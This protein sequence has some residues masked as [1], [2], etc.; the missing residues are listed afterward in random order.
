MGVNLVPIK[1]QILVN[2]NV[3]EPGYWCNSS[4]KFGREHP[5]FAHANNGLIVVA[6]LLGFLKRD[7]PVTYIDAA[8]CSNFKV[9]FHN[10]PEIGILFDLRA[11]FSFERL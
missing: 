4:C 5:Q 10:I 9:A 1:P 6:R 8:L 2:Q 3:P 7:D 11:R